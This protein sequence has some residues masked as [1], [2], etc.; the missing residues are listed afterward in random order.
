MLYTM[1]LKLDIKRTLWVSAEN[2]KACL[3]YILFVN[4]EEVNNQKTKDLMNSMS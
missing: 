2:T 1:R 4:R 3:N